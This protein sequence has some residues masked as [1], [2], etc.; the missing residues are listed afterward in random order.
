MWDS[1]TAGS[2]QAEKK[3]PD[4]PHPHVPVWLQG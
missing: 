1:G 2:V 3:G 4:R